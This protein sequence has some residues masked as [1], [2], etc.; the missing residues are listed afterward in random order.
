MLHGF[1]LCLSILQLS[2]SNVSAQSPQVDLGL[3]KEIV[4]KWSQ[5]HNTKDRGAFQELYAPTLLFYTKELPQKECIQIKLNRLNSS[6]LYSQ[7]ITSS[8]VNTFY[9][10]GIIKCDF[11]VEVT[12][13]TIATENRFYLLL[14]LRDNTYQIV[15]ESDPLTDKKLNYQLELGEQYKI[16][17]LEVVDFIDAESSRS[18]VISYIVWFILATGVLV[19]LFL[20][21]KRVNRNGKDST[22]DNKTIIES[23]DKHKT[24]LKR[25]GD[26]FEAFIF[27]RFDRKYFT[28]RYWNGDLSHKGFYPV[29]NTYPD[30]EIEFKLGDFKRVFAIECKFRSKLFKNSFELDTRNLENYRKYSQEKSIRVYIAV[31]LYGEPANPKRIYLIPLEIFSSK[32]SLSYD[33][34]LKFERGTNYFRYDRKY[35]MLI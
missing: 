1:F 31:G 30:L 15:G 24:E 17:E 29:S 19:V 20:I 35:D 27:E 12:A 7:K 8:L 5:A 9:K 32:N 2:I 4:E 10:S 16:N 3:I 33:E 34:L 23:I 6:K 18:S 11:T 21:Y 28:I 26:E 25:K 22:V 13:G 14:A